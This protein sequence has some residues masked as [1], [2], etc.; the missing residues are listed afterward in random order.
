MELFCIFV[1]ACVIEAEH[2]FKGHLYSWN[3]L[4]VLR[5]LLYV[6]GCFP[7]RF[8]MLN[9]IYVVHKCKFKVPH[10]KI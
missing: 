3:L 7:E 6:I 4:Q 2:N 10:I 1:C 8:P 9:R 5:F